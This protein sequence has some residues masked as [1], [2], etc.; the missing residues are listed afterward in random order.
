MGLKQGLAASLAALLLAGCAADTHAPPFA[1]RP[2]EAFSR[3]D[4]V[5]IAQR[6]WRLFASPVDDDP[7]GAR[8][9]PAPDAKPERVAGLWQR[10]GEYW[11]EALPPGAPEAGW[12]GRHDAAGR[13]FP[14]SRDGDY[15]WSAAFISYVMRI[16]G[17]GA[18][19][20]YS[21]DHAT[22]IN[23]ARRNEGALRAWPPDAYAPRLG[24]LIC[25]ARGDAAGLRF[26]DL[27]ARL[28]PAHCDLVVDGAPGAIAVIGGNVDDAVTLK[29]V[30][31]TA[32]GF[33]A[34]PDGRVLDARYRWFVVLQV[35][36]DR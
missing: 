26:A 10:V 22:Y 36:Y 32:D 30:P 7:P 17:A 2:Y 8:P 33:L 35:L 3:Q 31:V 5:A 9:P 13:V 25:I 24:D 6:E 21:A 29:H 34:A 23:A 12:T 19:F 27:P 11:W 14:A 20:P 16:A 15:A 4:A 18:H 28:F 1:T